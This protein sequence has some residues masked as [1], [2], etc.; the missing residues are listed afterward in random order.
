M[1]IIFVGK[2]LKVI[3]EMKKEM[4]YQIKMIK[5]DDKD[6]ETNE[7]ENIQ[8]NMNMYLEVIN[9]IY[10]DLITEYLNKDT[11]IFVAED[12]Y[13]ELGYDKIGDEEDE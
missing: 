6:F 5:L 4:I 3:E 2:P 1:N 7:I 11:K 12:S 13:G 8:H 9:G 10:Q